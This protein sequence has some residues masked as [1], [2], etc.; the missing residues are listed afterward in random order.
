MSQ[1][2]A[3]RGLNLVVDDI[4][5]SVAFYRTLGLEIPD[6]AVWRAGEMF[7]VEVEMPDGFKLELD[8]H[9]LARYYLGAELGTKAGSSQAPGGGVMGFGVPSREAVDER[10]A[11]LTAAGHKGLKAPFDAFWGARYAVVADPDG[12]P[13]GLMSPVDPDR[14]SAPPVS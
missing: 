14:R 12:N 9:G 13:V 3:L 8:S 1:S 5:A 7:H 4:D 11:A 2:V 10:F 6:E